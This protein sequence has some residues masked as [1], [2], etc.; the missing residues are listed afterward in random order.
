MALDDPPIKLRPWQRVIYEF[1]G[2]TVVVLA[3]LAV[4]AVTG[5]NVA[6]HAFVEGFIWFVALAVFLLFGAGHFNP[7]ITLVKMVLVYFLPGNGTRFRWHYVGYILVQYAGAFVA[8]LLVWA[9]TGDRTFTGLGMPV[10]GAGFSVGNGIASELIFSTF[11][12]WLYCETALLVYLYKSGREFMPHF[13]RALI[14]GFSIVAFTF[15]AHP[16]SGAN[17]NPFRFLGPALLAFDLG[18]NGHIYIWPPLLGAL[19]AGVA[20]WIQ[21]RFTIPEREE[22]GKRAKR[23]NT[24]IL[25]VS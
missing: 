11:I 19:L 21:L 3:G 22:S 5:G 17:F 12:I 13:L 16:V 4:V 6:A 14:I 2:S 18:T 20:L 7:A 1:I 25:T 8:A 15:V 24:P 10:L 9:L 23:N